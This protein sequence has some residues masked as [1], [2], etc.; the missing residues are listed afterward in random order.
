MSGLGEGG[1]VGLG[2][3][4]LV[5]MKLGAGSAS[6][7]LG[8]LEPGFA[9]LLVSVSPHMIQGPLPLQQSGSQA[10]DVLGH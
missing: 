6:Y 1:E 3:L 9:L 10:S 7:F 8:H 5:L 2:L 4:R